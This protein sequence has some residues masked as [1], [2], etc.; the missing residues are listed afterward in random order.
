[1]SVVVSTRD[2]GDFNLE[3]N[4]H[5]IVLQRCRGLIDRPWTLLSERHGV[6]AVEI[7]E[8]GAGFGAVGD[9][10]TTALT[11]TVVGVWVG[12]CAP[13]ALWSDAGRIAAVHAG[14]RGLVAGVLDRAV[15]TLAGPAGP[16]RVESGRVESGPARGGDGDLYAFV[17]PTIGP[18][19]YEFGETDLAQVAAAVGATH[20]QIAR[21]ETDGALSLD[22]VAA[23]RAA[24]ERRGVSVSADGRC[25]GCDLDLYSHRRRSESGRHVLGVW[26]SG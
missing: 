11:E 1:M 2:D 13:V 21:V 7:A 19:C 12:D 8:P 17:G 9:I 18:C 15:E 5:P 3:A 6:Q 4:P 22:V 23:V 14:W 25:T 24:L 26:R 20:E 16:G 10:V